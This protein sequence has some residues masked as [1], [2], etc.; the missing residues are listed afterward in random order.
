MDIFSSTRHPT[1]DIVPS[2][3][4]PTPPTW[5]VL[6]LIVVILTTRLITSITSSS[7]RKTSPRNGPQAV[8]GVPYSLPYLG[9]LPSMAWDS[10]NFIRSMT[11]QHTGGI[12]ALHL[13]GKKHN[14]VSSSRLTAALLSQ[15]SSNVSYE[16]IHRKLL[17]NVFG[18]PPSASARKIWEP[19]LPDIS[20]CYKNLLTDPSLP[21][22]INQ[23]VKTLRQNIGTLVS[24]AESPVDQ[25]LWERSSNI[26]TTKDPQGEEVVEASLFPLIRDFV[27]RTTTATLMGSTFTENF[28]GLWDDLWMLDHSYWLLA[29]G[30]PR[31]IP[32][33]GLMKAHIT[34]KRLLEMMEQFHEA[35]ER[36]AKGEDVGQEWSG[37]EDVS[38][39]VK[40]RVK[41]Y[42]KYGM[43]SRQRA[44]CELG[45]VWQANANTGSLVFWILNHI[46][47][48]RDLLTKVRE[49]IKPFVLAVQPKQEFAFPE[50]S[51]VEKM[52]VE[53][54]CRQCPLLE[55]CYVESLRLDSASWS[56]REVKQDFVLK[57]EEKEARGW[58]LRKGEYVHAAHDLHSTDAKCFGDPMV[59][60]ADRHIRN[61]YGEKQDT[62][63]MGSLRPYGGGESICPG[64]D[65][66]YKEVIS[67]AAA[68]IALWNIEPAGGG[69]WKMPRHRRA[70]GVYGSSDE[71][72]VWIK[73]RKLP[74]AS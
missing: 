20:A 22:M 73:R 54:L 57:S 59:W 66:A 12:F 31:W 37:L 9:H 16:P 35:L 44:A 70:T 2:G 62:T 50:P 67:F 17:I 52:D 68:A 24:G 63:D 36:E 46:Y 61:K 10:T 13:F 49:E 26:S 40:E 29:L 74:I 30:L 18:M 55:S 34:R 56:L 19:A 60:K 23:T 47:A 48:D 71:V 1:P 51:R 64:R 7:T 4:T 53:R 45:M 6:S 43:N 58:Q 28:E 69:E 5:I 65:L 32:V 8:P 41:V 21:E 42:R 72:R 15:S 38:T 11:F 39:L 14:I 33:P 27:A 3:Y 25:Q